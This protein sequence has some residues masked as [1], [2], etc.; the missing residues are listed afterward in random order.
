MKQIDD[1]HPTVEPLRLFTCISNGDSV[2]VNIPAIL[3]M[4]M[5]EIEELGPSARELVE[6]VHHADK[7][8][9]SFAYAD[10]ILSPTVGGL[11][12]YPTD[13]ALAAELLRIAQQSVA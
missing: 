7:L 4:H 1:D 11:I 8:H 13:E 10:E 2:R 3:D 9:V 12:A 6:A 5:S